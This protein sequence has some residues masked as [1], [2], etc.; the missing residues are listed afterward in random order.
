MYNPSEFS[1]MKPEKQEMLC[2]MF[3]GG[4]TMKNNLS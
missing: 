4:K 1:M 3:P 2:L